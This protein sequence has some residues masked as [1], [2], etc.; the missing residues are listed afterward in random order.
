LPYEFAQ[1]GS[2]PARL[3]SRTDIPP[4]PN[5][6]FVA[7]GRHRWLSLDSEASFRKRPHPVLGADSVEY[8]I[9]RHGYRT[10]ELDGAAAA[11]RDKLRVVCIGSSGAF[12]AGLPEAHTLPLVFRELLQKHSGREVV[13]WNL[14][15]GGTGADY[16]TRLLFSALPVLKPHVV[17]LTTF[18]FNRRE[19]VGENGR[20]VISSATPKW[21]QRFTDPENWQFEDVCRRICNPYNDLTNM[22]VNLKVWESLCDDAGVPWLF[23]TEAFAEQLVPLEP[24]LR[25]P[26][27]LVGPGVMALIRQYR[28]D[29]ATGL[30]RDM[31]HA[32]I[33]PTRVLAQTMFDRFLEIYPAQAA[34]LEQ[35]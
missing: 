5:L 14:S 24:L 16:V 1:I 30:A 19:F 12:G 35:I 26:R 20:I 29:P 32:G 11:A 3:F 18:P 17:L 9:N 2:A 8:G 21:H 6:S 10:S 13:A 33:E 28:D 23:T 34:A 4:C 7:P 22:V 27:K 31:L 15:A 25:E